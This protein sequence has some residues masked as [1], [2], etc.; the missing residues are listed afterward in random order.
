MSSPTPLSE[1]ELKMKIESIAIFL[2]TPLLV[3]II[4]RVE[5]RF[6]SKRAGWMTGFPIIAAPALLLLTIE[7]GASFGAQSAR[8]AFLGV[9]GWVAFV[10]CYRFLKGAGGA[11]FGIFLSL[12]LWLTSGILLGI[13]SPEP[14]WMLAMLGAFA[15]VGLVWGGA[16]GGPV[17][18]IK[19]FPGQRVLLSVSLVAATYL[20][21]RIGGH[22]V[23]GIMTTFPIL[24][25]ALLGP[26]YAGREYKTASIIASGM[27]VAGP[28]LGTF[29]LLV[30]YFSKTLSVATTFS[31]AIAFTVLVH[32]AMWAATALLHKRWSGA[33]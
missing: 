1:F 21:S 15:L 30:W 29:T 7:H 11:W 13:V 4:D 3:W 2:A 25:C 14:I 20:A 17:K 28:S 23:S 26:V 9:T 8:N 27:L 10:A 6:G 5:K 16:A 31:L 19:A 12:G 32:V 22:I 24:A 18:P 33:A